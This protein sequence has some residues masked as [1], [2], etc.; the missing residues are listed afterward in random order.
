MVRKL[1]QMILSL[2]FAK[3]YEDR[4]LEIDKEIGVNN[5]G[6]MRYDVAMR[7]IDL[8]ASSSTPGPAY[9]DYE[10]MRKDKNRRKR[11]RR[12]RR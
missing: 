2:R 11:N 1:D 7:D 8:L 5:S 6:T 4:V 12:K 9:I 10:F 3:E